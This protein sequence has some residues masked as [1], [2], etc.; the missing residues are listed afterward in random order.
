MHPC[1]VWQFELCLWRLLCL[2]CNLRQS[3]QQQQ[4]QQLALA[5]AGGGSLRQLQQQQHLQWL[6]LLLLLP[7][8]LRG[9]RPLLQSQRQPGLACAE[10]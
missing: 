2:Q 5:L 9:P 1:A 4:Q 8:A 7:C 6:L 10:A 3:Q